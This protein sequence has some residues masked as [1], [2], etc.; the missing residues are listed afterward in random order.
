MLSPIHS[1]SSYWYWVYSTDPCKD[2]SGS[3]DGF[4]SHPTR[5]QGPLPITSK[6]VARTMVRSHPH[7][8]R[9]QWPSKITWPS[10]DNHA[11]MHHPCHLV[12][13]PLSW[14][15][16]DLRVPTLFIFNLF[17]SYCVLIPLWLLHSAHMHT[18]SHS[19]LGGQFHPSYRYLLVSVLIACMSL[20]PCG[21]ILYK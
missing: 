5:P 2:P 17:L 8:L 16:W 3:T 6:V 11:T 19:Q 21:S 1:P 9:V 4:Q 20:W 15:T 7:G 14:W 12:S 13:R 18:C 10:H